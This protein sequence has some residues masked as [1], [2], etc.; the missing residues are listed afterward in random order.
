MCDCADLDGGVPREH[1][2][3]PP[4][5]GGAVLQLRL[6]Q[7]RPRL[8]QVGV[9][10]PAALGVKPLNIYCVF[11]LTTYTESPPLTCL[12]PSAPP[13]PSELL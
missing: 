6:P 2:E 12:P 8:V 1:E 9:V 11:S 3:V 10:R 13:L 7:Q 5:E 4:A